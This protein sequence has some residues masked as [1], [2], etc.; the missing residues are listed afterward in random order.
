MAHVG[1]AYPRCMVDSNVWAKYFF[2]PDQFS[3]PPY[4]WKL[5][6]GTGVGSLATKWNDSTR[7]SEVGFKNGDGQLEWH[8][9]YDGDPDIFF[10]LEGIQIEGDGVF[11]S[12]DTMYRQLRVSYWEGGVE[13][14][15]RSNYNAFQYCAD[16]GDWTFRFGSFLNLLNPALFTGFSL[17]GITIYQAEWSEVPDYHPYRH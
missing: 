13:Y 1:K 6:L 7:F 11:G 8:V 9:E 3:F 5:V 2:T 4:K 17:D 14:G 15:D 10:K 16:S 12:L